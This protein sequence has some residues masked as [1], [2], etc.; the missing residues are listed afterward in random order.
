MVFIKSTWKSGRTISVL[1]CHTW[2]HL[3]EMPEQVETQ[4]DYSKYSH[5][6]KRCLYFKVL[7]MFYIKVASVFCKQHVT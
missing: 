3:Y 1:C 5:V 6:I 2:H 7:L 4:L